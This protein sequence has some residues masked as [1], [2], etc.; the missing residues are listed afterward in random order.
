MPQ[1]QLL[2]STLKRELKAEGKT[3]ADVAECLEIS[4]ASVKR[5]FTKGQF[6]LERLDTLCEWLGTDLT[7][8]ARRAEASQSQLTQLTVDQEKEIASDEL[9]LLVAVCLLNHYQFDDI[10]AQFAVREHQ[11][12]QVLAKLDRLK[13]ITLL[14]ENRVKLRVSRDFSWLPGGPI[15]TL[16][17]EK[18]AAEFFQSPFT[19]KT[20]QLLVSN[21]LLSQDA[22]RQF[23]E[24]MQRLLQEFNQLAQDQQALPMDDKRGFTLV[25]AMRHWKYSLFEQISRD[26]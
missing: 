24:K 16:F 6:T 9:V 26:G 13:F 22:N 2:I 10:L 25:V 20:E 11:L 15:Q 7:S 12:I 5:L 19:Q 14:P 4:E 8:L 1:S 3:Y 21:G 17:L 23:Q 18:I